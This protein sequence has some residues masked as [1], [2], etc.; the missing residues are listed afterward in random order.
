MTVAIADPFRSRSFPR[1]TPIEL[2]AYRAT[3]LPSYTVT[4]PHGY[5]ATRIGKQR[6]AHNGT[7]WHSWSL[8]LFH[9]KSFYTFCR[10]LNCVPVVLLDNGAAWLPNYIATKLFGY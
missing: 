6:G 9:P 8:L 1:R 3:H 2:H 4:E 5:T 7:P 10:P